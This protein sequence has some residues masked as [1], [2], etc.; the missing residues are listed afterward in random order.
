MRLSYVVGLIGLACVG[1]GGGAASSRVESPGEAAKSGSCSALAPQVLRFG[2][3]LMDAG[4]AS[5]ARTGSFAGLL[6]LLVTIEGASADLEA[7]LAA[8]DAA[9]PSMADVMKRIRET[10][11]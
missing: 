9:D 7:Q 11:E 10:L 2:E 4:A 1:C 6:E 8:S 5:A 3:T